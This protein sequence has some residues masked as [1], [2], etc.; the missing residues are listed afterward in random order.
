MGEGDQK[1]LGGAL[2]ASII[3][4]GAIGVFVGITV[5][6]VVFS[7]LARSAMI[8]SYELGEISLRSASDV[9]FDDIAFSVLIG[10]AAGVITLVVIYGFFRLGGDEE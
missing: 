9:L 1:G 7:A 2:K 6:M 4:R 5:A 8:I 10:M 3:Y